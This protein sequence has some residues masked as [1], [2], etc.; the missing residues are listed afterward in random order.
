MEIVLTELYA[1]RSRVAIQES[2]HWPAW[3]RSGTTVVDGP[4]VQKTRIT[5]LT[6]SSIYADGIRLDPPV[7]DGRRSGCAYDI[8]GVVRIERTPAG[9]YIGTVLRL[10]GPAVERD[11]GG[12]AAW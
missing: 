2:P 4:G 9:V 5:T 11:G 6:R 3:R 8:S 12:S 10:V 7:S 1:I